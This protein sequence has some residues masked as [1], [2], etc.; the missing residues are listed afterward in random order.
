M[1]SAISR[2]INVSE[3]VRLLLILVFCGD[4]TSM[5]H[6][7][8][9]Q[10][11]INQD[12]VV[13]DALSLL[14]WK[15]YLLEPVAHSNL[16]IQDRVL[17]LCR[18]TNYPRDVLLLDIA[19][20]I[21]QVLGTSWTNRVFSW[22]F[23]TATRSAEEYEEQPVFTNTKDGFEV[24]LD[25]DMIKRS[26]RAFNPQTTFKLEFTHDVD[27]CLKYMERS[28]HTDG[29]NYEF[30]LMSLTSSQEIFRENGSI[31]VKQFVQ[32][33]GL[34][35]VICCLAADEY[36]SLAAKSVIGGVAQ[37]LSNP[38]SVSS[39]REGSA[40]RI[41]L[42]KVL[43]FFAQGE[44]EKT[45]YL[46]PCVCKAMALTL[47][48]L[49][50]PG[51]FLHE[52][53]TDFILS[54]PGLRVAEI[55][56]FRSISTTHS[57]NAVRELQWLLDSLTCALCVGRDATFYSQRGLFEWALSLRELCPEMST[58]VSS[59]I[60]KAQEVSGG[61]MSLITSNAGLSWI[62]KELSQDKQETTRKLGVRFVVTSD[63]ARLDQWADGSIRAF[64]D[65]LAL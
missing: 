43:M 33:N 48:I 5:E 44:G 31:D 18:G 34:S 15:L 53:A 50:N 32:S 47:P 13:T 52:K 22:Q 41:F 62:S 54:G 63:K 25:S 3:V 39:Y 1:E 58:A 37:F 40:I 38:E 16:H 8:H 51:H 64:M 61:S 19:K 10:M 29:Y 20:H 65:G 57:D 60:A 30:L 21:E 42:M 11:I 45:R 26:V 49:A 59:L 7:K 24:S 28:P 9:L 55:P 23:Q 36:L 14:I 6:T 27:D 35:F 4:K 12:V 56:M 17:L 2:W 46:L